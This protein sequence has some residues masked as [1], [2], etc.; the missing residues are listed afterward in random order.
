[1]KRLSPV[2]PQCQPNGTCAGVER[3][4]GTTHAQCRREEERKVC[5]RRS[6]AVARLVAIYV[7]VSGL[8]I[9]WSD[10]LVSALVHD[11][12]MAQHVQTYKGWFFVAVTGVL[13]G[14]LAQRDLKRAEEA[15]VVLR[16]SRDELEQAEQQLAEARTIE[17]TERQ[18]SEAALRESE[19]KFRTLVE[20]SLTGA[21]IIQDSRFVYVNPGLC[22]TFGYSA[23]ELRTMD[24]LDIVR[25]DDRAQVAEN[26]RKRVD[27]EVQSI[28]YSFR[29]RHKDGRRLEVE[30]VGS[31]TELN[32]RPAIIGTALDVTARKRAQEQEYRLA[33]EKDHLIERLQLHFN[34]M[35]IGCIV[36]APDLTVLDWNPAAA[37]IFGF[38]DQEMVGRQPYGRIIPAAARESVERFIAELLHGNQTRSLVQ[39]NETKEGRRIFCEWHDTPLRDESGLVIGIIAMVQD[40]TER[41]KTEAALRELSARLLV[42]QDEERRRIARE[43]HDTTAQQL[44]ALAL[45][46]SVISKL[47]ANP[48]PK[49]ARILTDTLRLVET[50]AQEVRTTSYLLHPPLLEAAGL[51]GTVRDY[52]GGFARRSGLKVNLDLQEDLGRLPPDAELALFRMVQEGLGNI[53]R[54]SG[55]ATATIRLARETDRVSLEL[56]DTGHGVPAEILAA[57]RSKTGAV[58]VGIAGMR[59]RLHQLNGGLEIESGPGGTTVRATLVIGKTEQTTK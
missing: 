27:N 22:N 26:L 58:G 48:S 25:E 40:V 30:V 20:Q 38:S 24:L 14:W 6:F 43:L 9:L 50:T 7:V 59:E 10:H 15:D 54:H 46:L 49:V 36:T 3:S 8:W 52:A 32:G 5:S 41:I 37:S 34:A 2:T 17:I 28:H 33:T 53:H 23:E 1:M 39:E 31:R 21:Y 29:A 51:V 12:R 42:A 47:V 44:A 55:S 35:P 19:A 13:L 4:P 57:L 45:N 16:Q 56:K 18:R 11:A